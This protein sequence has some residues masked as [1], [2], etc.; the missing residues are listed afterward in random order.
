MGFGDWLGGLFGGGGGADLGGSGNFGGELAGGSYGPLL[1]DSA[2]AAA[3]AGGGGFGGWLSDVGSGVANMGAG[4][5]M[6]ALGTAG[7]LGSTGLGMYGGIKQMQ[8]G[9]EQMNVLKQQQKQQ[10]EMARPAAQAGGALTAAGSAALQGGALPPALEAQV[11]DFKNNARMR[12]RQM[13]AQTG[14]TDSTAGTQMDAWVE[15]QALKL[16]GE[17]A[18]GLYQQ[19]LGGISAAM[20]PSTAVSQTA[21]G[22]A[23]GTQGSLAAANKAL[24]DLLGSQ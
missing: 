1:G 10:Q 21:M 7:Q 4:D 12:Y 11:E 24:A 19:G 17:L 5:W 2:G 22:M 8:Q 18:G 20:G 6:K 3:P 13:L 14:Q 15:A 23:G 16:R 9:A